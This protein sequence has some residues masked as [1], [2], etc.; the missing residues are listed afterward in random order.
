MEVEFVKSSRGG[1]LMKDKANFLY[2]LKDDNKKKGY[3]VC[4][5]YKK[6]KSACPVSAVLDKETGLVTYNSDHNHSTVKSKTKLLA[7]KIIENAV[8]TS[9]VKT[10]KVLADITTKVQITEGTSMGSIGKKESIMRTI[11]YY[12]QK[13]D[14]KPADPKKAEDIFNMPDKFRMTS[15]NSVFLRASGLIGEDES[16]VYLIY[17]S[18]HGKH[19]LSTYTSWCG[20]GHFSTV[21]KGFK[22]IYTIGV[23]TDFGNFIPAAFMLLPGKSEEVYSTVF[24]V[25]TKTVGNVSH[26]EKFS[27]DFERA[28]HNVVEDLLPN[29]SISGCLFHYKQCIYRKLGEYGCLPVYHNVDGFKKIVDFMYALPFVPIDQIVST[30]DEVICPLFT[31]HADKWTSSDSDKDFSEEV[32]SYKAYLEKNW[33]GAVIRNRGRRAPLWSVDK[34]NKYDEVV[35]EDFILTNNGNEV[36]NSVWVPSIPKNA[37]LWTILDNF[38]N[39]E[40][41]ARLTHNEVLR[42]VH[43]AHNASRKKQHDNKMRELRNICQNFRGF[44]LAE[45]LQTVANVF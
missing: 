38:K 26:V 32:R 40:S 34:Y 7:K 19:L 15:D 35:G 42:N 44:Q 37:S 22:Q 39:E 1:N 45:Y 10:R 4:T 31:E 29:A 25:I 23:H 3:Y 21:P 2:Y 13:N 17:M 27:C 36:F 14:G 28:V 12:K 6:S 8:K 9:D 33:V 41:L 5:E 30:Y 18:D 20:D 16:M 43:V 24:S 11:R